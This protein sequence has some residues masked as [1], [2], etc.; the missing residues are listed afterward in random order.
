M[1]VYTYEFTNTCPADGDVIAYRLR[2]RSG[3][4]I[5]AEAIVEAC[6]LGPAFHEHIADRLA[7]TLPGEQTLVARHRGVTITTTR[8]GT[9]Q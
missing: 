4:M 9:A 3:G 2:I 6:A 8:K 1:N 7:G 5:R